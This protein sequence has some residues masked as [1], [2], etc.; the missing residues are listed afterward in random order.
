MTVAQSLA[1]GRR[2]QAGPIR[3]AMRDFHTGHRTEIQNKKLYTKLQPTGTFPPIKTILKERISQF[4]KRKVEFI[5]N[6]TH[7]YSILKTIWVL[8]Y[9]L[10]LFGMTT[11]ANVSKR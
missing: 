3:A 4:Y 1:G 2:G 5:S 7:C 9:S 6:N 8:S 11:I 10:T